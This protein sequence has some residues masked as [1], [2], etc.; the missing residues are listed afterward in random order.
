MLISYQIYALQIFSPILWVAF[1][2]FLIVSFDK[3]KDKN[4]SFFSF[5]AYAFVVISKKSF[6]NPVS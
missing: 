2:L 5:V 3:E 4:L 6:A 1:L